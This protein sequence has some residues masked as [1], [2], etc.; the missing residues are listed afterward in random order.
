VFGCKT[1]ENLEH[2]EPI[3]LQSSMLKRHIPKG[4]VGSFA[5][6]TNGLNG[7]ALQPLP[8][9]DFGLRP[10]KLINREILAAV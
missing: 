2:C 8:G 10:K 6:L 5:L 7:R 1:G 3:F 9:R 4:S